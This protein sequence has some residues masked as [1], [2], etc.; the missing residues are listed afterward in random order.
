[1]LKFSKKF[2]SHG[3][4]FGYDC[5]RNP[6][7]WNDIKNGKPNHFALLIF[8]SSSITFF[9]H[10]F[11]LLTHTWAACVVPTPLSASF[12]SSTPS[13]RSSAMLTRAS[14][15]CLVSCSAYAS[16]IQNR[17]PKTTAATKKPISNRSFPGCKN[18]GKPLP[19][20]LRPT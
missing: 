19:R 20:A 10:V 8:V 14:E 15:I 3:N 16:M 11:D 17:K 2:P 5:S 7:V 9:F 1:M 18:K 6:W 13:A 4:V 12:R